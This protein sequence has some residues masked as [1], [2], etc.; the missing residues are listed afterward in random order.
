[1]GVPHQDLLRINLGCGLQAPDGGINVDGS[2]NARLAKHPRIRHLFSSLH[3]VA[4]DKAGIPWSSK[5]YI[6]DVRKPLPFSDCS[7][8]AICTFH[9]LEHLYFE[10]GRQLIL[11]PFRVLAGGAY[12]STVGYLY[13]RSKRRT[14]ALTLLGSPP[15]GHDWKAAQ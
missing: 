3:L 11:E 6:H 12:H 10:V 9:L 5:I 4:K 15:S 2:W 1:M 13:S 7:A 8:R 14:L